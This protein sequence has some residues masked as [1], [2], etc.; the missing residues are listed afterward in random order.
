[1]GVSVILSLCM[2]VCPCMCVCVCLCMC[3]CVHIF[4]YGPYWQGVAAQVGFNG[5]MFILHLG[6]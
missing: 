2:C 4:T 3:R 5:S 1:M 6:V